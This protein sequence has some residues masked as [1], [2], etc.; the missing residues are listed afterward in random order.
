MLGDADVE[1]QEAVSKRLASESSSSLSRTSSNSSL[2]CRDMDGVCMISVVHPVVETKDMEA[3]SSAEGLEP[4]ARG[5][6]TDVVELQGGGYLAKTR[7]WCSRCKYRNF[8][9]AVLSRQGLLFKAFPGESHGVSTQLLVCFM[10]KSVRGVGQATR[11]PRLGP[12][13]MYDA[14]YQALGQP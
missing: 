9:M 7:N 8:G 4:M 1:Q 6:H 13:E 2:L 10:G 5:G 14:E 12:R 3:P 11:P